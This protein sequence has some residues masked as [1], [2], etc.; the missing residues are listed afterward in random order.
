MVAEIVE[1]SLNQTASRAGWLRWR[2]AW[3]LWSGRR[4]DQTAE[5]GATS[6]R[7]RCVAGA[8]CVLLIAACASGCRTLRTKRHTR[9][10]TAARQLS[11]R[12]ADHLQQQN[13][14][15]AEPLFSEA[16]KHS[17]ADERAHW[18]KAEVL[19]T[20]GQREQAIAHMNQAVELSGN[21]PDLLVRLGE[22]YL[23]EDQLEAALQQADL[24]LARDR[25]HPEAWALKGRVLRLRNALPDSLDCYQIALIHKPVNPDVRLAL[26]DIYDAMGRPQRALATLDQL[27]DD[28]PTEQI[29]A[30]AW[31]LKGQS[32]AALGQSAEARN[33][34]QQ[35][36]TCACESETELL[37]DLAQLQYESGDLAE[38]RICLG[39]ALRNNPHDPYALQ[40][41][42]VLDQS[43]RQYSR[44]DSL[45]SQDLSG[46]NPDMPRVTTQPAS[47][48]Q[49]PIPDAVPAT[50][51]ENHR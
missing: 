45:A 16:L 30:R 49:V 6:R 33:C 29:P 51:S 4:T 22:M 31:M 46:S 27:A 34:L 40:F 42:N 44:Q 10:L 11:L 20:Q 9:N 26:A 36:A 23:D 14:S 2:A 39:R 24:V 5:A 1:N 13:Y 48:R 37:L 8:C 21:N 28:Q 7:R 50:G 38:A 12:G 17:Y 41:Q 47:W 18:G 35:A 19:W 43:F 15:E 25:Q 3:R 32:L